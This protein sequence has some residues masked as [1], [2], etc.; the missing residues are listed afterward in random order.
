MDST[1]CPH[2]QGQI[3]KTCPK[4]W[5]AQKPRGALLPGPQPG[6]TEVWVRPCPITLLSWLHRAPPGSRPVPDV[7]FQTHHPTRE[8]SR[9][10]AV[11]FSIK[12]PSSVPKHTVKT[13][14]CKA[15]RSPSCP[16]CVEPQSTRELLLAPCHP[17]DLIRASGAAPWSH[18]PC[19]T[20]APPGPKDGPT[21]PGHGLLPPSVHLA[22][23]KPVDG[24]THC[25]PGSDLARKAQ[26]V[27]AS[28]KQKSQQLH[29]L[30]SPMSHMFAPA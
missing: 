5:A 10:S 24:P 14:T 28:Q 16:A 3:G 22:Q 20:S 19:N 23:P 21:Y 26:G 18:W 17:S 9:F 1:R 6:E 8:V 4:P 25:V 7:P 2:F 13:Y 29:C 30:P 27:G 11:S 12:K 15:P